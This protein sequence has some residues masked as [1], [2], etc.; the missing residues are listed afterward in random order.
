MDGFVRDPGQIVRVS[1]VEFVGG[2]VERFRP[3]Y[4][5]IVEVGRLK[6]G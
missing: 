5:A 4:L 3:G 2:A 6:R 1:E